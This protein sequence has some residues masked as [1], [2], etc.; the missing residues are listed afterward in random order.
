MK[1]FIRGV[2]LFLF[3]FISLVSA[4][5]AHTHGRFFSPKVFLSWSAEVI[6]Q[7]DEIFAI[8]YTN[9]DRSSPFQNVLATTRR[10]SL[11]KRGQLKE[12]HILSYTYDCHGMSYIYKRHG[13]EFVEVKRVKIK[14]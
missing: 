13:N 9:P 5:V 7:D 11:F 8:Q 10:I 12:E 4:A 6:L 14:G 3:C 2:L 1:E